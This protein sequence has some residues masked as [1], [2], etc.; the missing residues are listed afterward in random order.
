MWIEEKIPV[1]DSARAI[2]YHN[3]LGGGAV[4]ADDGRRAADDGSRQGSLNGVG[5]LSKLGMLLPDVLHH[6]SLRGGGHTHIHTRNRVLP[7][8]KS[9]TTWELFVGCYAWTCERCKVPLNSIQLTLQKAA[10]W[11]IENNYFFNKVFKLFD[12]IF[13]YFKYNTHM[14]GNL[15]F[16]NG[17]QA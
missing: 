8:D 13:I 12:A 2:T 1:S 10:V 16:K 9:D 7:W 11:Q 15:P 5:E 3:R 14:K 4:G 17:W 6:L